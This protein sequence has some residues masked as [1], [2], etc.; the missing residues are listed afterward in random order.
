MTIACP[1]TTGYSDT[2]L[3]NGVTYH[4]AVSATYTGGPNA[5]GASSESSEVLATPPCATPTYLGTL[6]A[7]KSGPEDAV[8]SW[9]SGGASAFDLVRGDLETLRATGGSFEAALDALPGGENACLE[10]NTVSLSVND[11]Y[12][13]PT[14]GAGIFTL[15]RP[16]TTGCAAVGTLD[17]GTEVGSRDADVA[18]SSRAC[19]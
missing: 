6:G 12:S 2:G 1:A 15:L 11:P 10:N 17:D 19:P 9:N 16:V 5:G 7:S 3:T 18:A 8:W 4:Y 13:A 14:P